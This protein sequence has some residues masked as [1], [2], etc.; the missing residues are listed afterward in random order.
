MPESG[1]TLEWLNV[2][3]VHEV[4]ENLWHVSHVFGK[5]ACGTGVVALAKS[6]AW[7][8][9]HGVFGTLVKLPLV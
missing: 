3:C 1:K 8:A 9:K 2:A 4:S 5:L 7:Q 6:V